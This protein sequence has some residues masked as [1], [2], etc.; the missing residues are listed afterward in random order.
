[1]RLI[2]LFL[3]FAFV[4]QAAVSANYTNEEKEALSQL[5]V[6]IKNI[7]YKD[8]HNLDSY[9]INFLRRKK[10]SVPETKKLL[11]ANF[12]WRKEKKIDMI[13]QEKNMISM[14]K[15]FP[16]N[17]DGVDKAGRPI[18]NYILHKWDVRRFILAGKRDE[19]R[20]YQVYI[21]EKVT[22]KLL[23]SALSGKDVSQI[24]ILIDL[25]GFNTRQHGCLPCLQGLSDFVPLLDVNYPNIA[26]QVL[27]VN[28]PRAFE[29]IITLMKGLIPE[30]RRDL[31]RVFG[32]DKAEWRAYLSKI[33]D[34]DQI[35]A[36]F[37]G[38]R[39]SRQ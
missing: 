31:F 25:S 2:F 21:I 24:V 39:P 28:A 8:Y 7:V 17:I 33:V 4:I 20:R 32:Y 30:S 22:Q 13:L 36:A 10:L 6:A 29:T 34:D 38:T 23:A 15:S 16:I 5:K 14:E 12:K 3:S 18:L 9:L 1:M 11:E 35:P 27:F 37:G 19:Y 26:H